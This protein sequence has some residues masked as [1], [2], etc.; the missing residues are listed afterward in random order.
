M[1]FFPRTIPEWNKLPQEV[2]TAE[3]LDCFKSRLASHLQKI[4]SRV[5]DRGLEIAGWRPRVGDR[6][7][8]VAGWRPQVG[9]RKLGA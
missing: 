6:G 5:G 7:L 2:V 9:S 4:G 3:S 8:E 1:A